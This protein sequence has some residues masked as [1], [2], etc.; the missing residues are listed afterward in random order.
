MKKQT[1]YLRLS[2][3]KKEEK[4]ILQEA[5]FEGALKVTRP[6]YLTQSG[7]AYLYIMN[8]GG[9]Y[10]DGDFYRVEIE[11]GKDAEAVLTT[12]SSTKIYKTL[13]QPALQEVEI[14]L[15]KGSFLEYLPDPII[16]YQYAQFK[17]QTIVR[18]EKG[19]SF[20]CTD[21]CTPGWSPDGSLFQYDLLQLRL[22]VYLDDQLI[23]FD[24]VKL[25]PDQ[26][27]KEMGRMEEYTHFGTLVVIN[28]H[29]NRMFLDELY[30][31]LQPFCE[32]RIGFS[33]L[34]VPGFALRVLANSTQ[35]IEK[36][37]NCCHEKIRKQISE[38][39]FAFLR[40]Y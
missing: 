17:Q 39:P 8:P 29:I 27:M 13:N 3:A 1:G 26:G 7:E 22:D 20:I 11:L 23:L 33:M 10:L 40:K 38:K 25:S 35:E 15:Q 18:M 28:E 36:I 24:H 14:R 9:G 21:I 6:V 4:T 31:L 30:E 34:K 16:A 37:I 2:F 12:Q 19:A 32:S 5:Y